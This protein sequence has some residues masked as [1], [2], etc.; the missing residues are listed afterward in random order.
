[1]TA[2]PGRTQAILLDARLS[3][4][5]LVRSRLV[6]VPVHPVLKHLPYGL[7]RAGIQVRH[8]MAAQ[9][10]GDIGGFVSIFD[11]PDRP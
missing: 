10:C 4:V 9:A 8:Q 11:V 1:M 2:R 6:V 3:R 5:L 7:S